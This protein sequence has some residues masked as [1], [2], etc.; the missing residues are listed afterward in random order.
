MSPGKAVIRIPLEAFFTIEFSVD[1]I[2]NDVPIIFGLEHHRRLKSSSNEVYATFTQHPSK[3][4]VP[5]I[6]REDSPGQGG[7]LF[8]IW[9]INDVLYT[10]L[11]LKKLH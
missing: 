6:F 9:A 3:T 10:N 1:L 4:T 2:E 7:Y 5:V 11:E 8:L